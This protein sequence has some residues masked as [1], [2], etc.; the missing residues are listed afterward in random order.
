MNPVD[1]S[2]HHVLGVF[3]KA[4]DEEGCMGLVP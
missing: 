4:F 3:G 1:T 2:D